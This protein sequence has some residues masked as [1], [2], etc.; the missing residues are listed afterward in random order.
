MTDILSSVE[1][2]A[3]VA[4]TKTHSFLPTRFHG[5]PC[6]EIICMQQRTYLVAVK[7]YFPHKNIR[8]HKTA[9][10]THSHT[11]THTQAH[12]LARG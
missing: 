1:Y 10:H 2:V 6:F 8:K 7:L 9:S 11:H 5:I 12:T 4:A 3:I